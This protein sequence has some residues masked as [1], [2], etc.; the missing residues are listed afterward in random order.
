MNSKMFHVN[1]GDMQVRI[2][3]IKNGVKGITNEFLVKLINEPNYNH[4]TRKCMWYAKQNKPWQEWSIFRWRLDKRFI[5]E[6]W[7]YYGTYII[8]I[9]VIVEL[10]EVRL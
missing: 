4:Y 8:E 5:G 3:E 10:D 2:E 9:N 6:G 7:R 1:N